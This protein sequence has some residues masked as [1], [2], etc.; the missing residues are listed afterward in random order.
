M[1]KP[2]IALPGVALVTV[3]AAAALAP[4]ASASVSTS[5]DAAQTATASTADS[6]YAA[7]LV[8][9]NEVPVKGGPKVGDKNGDAYAVIRIHGNEI[10]YAVRW[11]G[12]A[13]PT[14]FHIHSGKAGKNG[15]VK[16]PFFME[17][18]PGSAKA[19]AGTV[20]ADGGTVS[21]I[22]RNPS[23]W[24]FNVHT[25]EFPGGAVR[26]QLR[27]IRPIQLAAILAQDTHASFHALANGKN[28][29]PS[30]GK[31]VGDKNGSAEWIVGIRGSKLY[32]AT[33][34]DRIAAPTNGHIHSGKKG[35][36]GPVA[37]DLF[38]DSNGL[39]KGVTGIAGSASVKSSV[40]GGIKKNPKNWYTNLHTSE[41]PDGAVRGQLYS[42][43]AGW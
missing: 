42:S 27:K 16:V 31:K 8:G 34:W 26:A 36:N 4:A 23:N 3:V 22:K 35:V 30:P 10:S 38:A 5:A 14:A 39:P 11:D 12:I 28:E 7:T 17:A 21:G 24:Y 1:F 19:L 40:A 33:I 41:F 6:Y 9:K 15:D 29:V 25:G 20:K 32:Y 18:L 13:T 37:V 43:H 2:T